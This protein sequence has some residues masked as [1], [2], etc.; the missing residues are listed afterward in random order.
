MKNNQLTLDELFEM[1]SM[2]NG[3]NSAG[4]IEYQGQ[5]FAYKT[6]VES[7]AG[8]YAANVNG[9]VLVD[10]NVITPGV[11]TIGGRKLPAGVTQLVER[12]AVLSEKPASGSTTA[13]NALLIAAEFNSAAIAA[14]KNGVLRFNQNAELLRVS[15]AAVSPHGTPTSIDDVFKSVAPFALRGGDGSPFDITMELSGATLVANHAYKLMWE[16]IE[17]VPANNA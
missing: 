3:K 7:V 8:F 17:F 11:R 16:A 1:R 12:V 15:G 6:V 10:S 5:K 13:D 9:A 2:I 14:F 4:V